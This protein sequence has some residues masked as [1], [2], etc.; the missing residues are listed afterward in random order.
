MSFCDI[1]MSRLL[2]CIM[3]IWNYICEFD[4]TSPNVLLTPSIIRHNRSN[5]GADMRPV[6]RFANKRTVLAAS[7]HGHTDILFSKCTFLRANALQFRTIEMAAIMIDTV[8]FIYK[9]RL[10]VC[11]E[12]YIYLKWISYNGSFLLD[13]FEYYFPHYFCHIFVMHTISLWQCNQLS[14]S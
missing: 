6:K 5:R 9:E 2:F 14:I 3:D 1:H 12:G 8:V 13:S 4:V 11:L 10:T 7:H